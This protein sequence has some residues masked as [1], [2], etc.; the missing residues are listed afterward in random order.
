LVNGCPA[1]VTA[2]KLCNNYV[3]GGY[4]DW[5]L[6]SK[7]ELGR[8][9]YSFMMSHFGSINLIS[10]SEVSSTQIWLGNYWMNPTT[11]YIATKGVGDQSVFPFRD[12]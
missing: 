1:A 6:P 9:T 10:S 3:S 12:F 8:I 7:D 4:D 5:Y 11:I 2:A